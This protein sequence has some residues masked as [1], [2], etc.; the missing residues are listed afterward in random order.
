MQKELRGWQSAK[1]ITRNLHQMG[2]QGS[3]LYLVIAN[4]S[5]KYT[6]KMLH[7]KVLKMYVWYL[8]DYPTKTLSPNSR[9]F[10]ELQ[11][12]IQ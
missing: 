3:K 4:I 10:I 11:K 8:L 12:K 5:L 7:E 1:V 9:L 6:E 2:R